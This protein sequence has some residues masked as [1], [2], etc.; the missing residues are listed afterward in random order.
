[1]AVLNVQGHIAKGVRNMYFV[2]WGGISNPWQFLANCDAER[3]RPPTGA[4]LK[5]LM[6]RTH[7]NWPVRITACGA[8]TLS[9]CLVCG[10]KEDLEDR[11]GRE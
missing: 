7:K 4:A 11:L 5:F 10:T 2:V 8:A 1:M 6:V 3:G 9:T